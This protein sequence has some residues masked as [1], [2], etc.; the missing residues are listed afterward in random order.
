MKVDPAHAASEYVV[1]IVNAAL[2]E[3]PLVGLIHP[4]WAGPSACAFAILEAY[5]EC[6]R[7]SDPGSQFTLW[8]VPDLDRQGLLLLRGHS[9]DLTSIHDWLH[10]EQGREYL[11]VGIVDGTAIAVFGGTDEF[12]ELI[13]LARQ[14]D[15]CGEFAVLPLS[16]LLDGCYTPRLHLIDAECANERGEVP[17][18]KFEAADMKRNRC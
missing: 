13:D 8:S 7:Q 9:N 11:A 10:A 16:D 1:R 4:I 5:L 15:P 18:G 17:E 2:Y 6:V 14:A 12:E 3:A